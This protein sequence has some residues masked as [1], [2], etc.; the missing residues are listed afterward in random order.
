MA[1]QVKGGEML[2]VAGKEG[3]L[4]RLRWG[5]LC[6]LKFWRN[7][8]KHEKGGRRDSLSIPRFSSATK[9]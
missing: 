8:P 7:G 4:R 9:P 1:E 3:R 6:G 5:L 2:A